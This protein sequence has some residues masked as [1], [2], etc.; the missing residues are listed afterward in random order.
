L[1]L[2]NWAFGDWRTT[3]PSQR[4]RS[5]IGTTIFVFPQAESTSAVYYP[6]SFAFHLAYIVGI[7]ALLLIFAAGAAAKARRT[8]LAKGTPLEF[9]ARDAR[10]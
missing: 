5:A 4:F 1:L 10:A 3:A 2:W 8:V 7:V 9:N 6:K